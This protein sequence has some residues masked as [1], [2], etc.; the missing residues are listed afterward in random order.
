M[1]VDETQAPGTYEVK[2]DASALASGVYVYRLAAG[3]FAA[4]QENDSHEVGRTRFPS[5][6]YEIDPGR[7]RLCRDASV[8]VLGMYSGS[9]IHVGTII[10]VDGTIFF[11]GSIEACGL[12]RS[13]PLASCRSRLLMANQLRRTSLPETPLPL[14]R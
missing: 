8:V 11:S 6:F 4:D 14:P 5:S 10:R 2:F 12:A 3:R 9:R 7:W 1:L 13:P